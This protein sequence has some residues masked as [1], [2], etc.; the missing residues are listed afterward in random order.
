MTITD[1]IYDQLCAWEHGQK[2]RVAHFV[3]DD[4]H[5]ATKYTLSCNL[6]PQGHPIGYCFAATSAS[7]VL[8]YLHHPEASHTYQRTLDAQHMFTQNSPLSGAMTPRIGVL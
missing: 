3:L 8:H 5:L 4:S 2:T 6:N 7:R 1:D